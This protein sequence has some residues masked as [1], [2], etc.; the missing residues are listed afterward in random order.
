M[1]KLKTWTQQKFNNEA[2]AATAQE[3][4][5]KHRAEQD[6]TDLFTR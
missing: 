5:R 3:D 4:E 1:E 2:A 6:L